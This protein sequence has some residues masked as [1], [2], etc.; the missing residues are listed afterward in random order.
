MIG[1]NVNA[2]GM[3]LV[4]QFPHFKF[5]GQRNDCKNWQ[6]QWEDYVQLIRQ[7]YGEPSSYIL[8]SWLRDKMDPETGKEIKVRMRDP[9]VKYN[10]VYAEIC[11]RF[12]G[13]VGINGRRWKRVKFLQTKHG[14]SLAEWDAFG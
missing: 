5:S 4:K 9:Q 11:R 10:G 1:E 3:E 2:L 13:E 8:L 14:V 6:D 12:G 7:V